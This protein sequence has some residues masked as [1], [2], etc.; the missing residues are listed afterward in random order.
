MTKVVSPSA[1]SIT[2]GQVG[3]LQE[4]LGAAL[5]KSGLQSE[6][7]QQVLERD[8]GALA[9]E[10]VASVRKRVE[11]VSNL[12]TRRVKVDRTRTPQEAI[13]ATSR[14][15]YLDKKVVATMP[16]GEGSEAEV[17][18]FNLGRYVSD[19]DLEKGYEL[20]GL[21]PADLYSVAAVNEVD[22]TFADEYPNGTHW[23][24]DKGKWCFAAF[25]RWRGERR[26]GVDRRDGRDWFDYWWFAG[27][28]K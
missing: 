27:L 25:S 1:S 7:T 11:A 6:P 22:P 28:R 13:V 5:R 9:D 26:V 14:A 2:P 4:L 23:K 18:F 10:F 19:D 3:K 24:D 21:K 15:Q 16:R 17:F 12:I 20:R 8:G